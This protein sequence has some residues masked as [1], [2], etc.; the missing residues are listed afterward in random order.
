MLPLVQARTRRCPLLLYLEW[1]YDDCGSRSIDELPKI[2]A[3]LDQKVKF[4]GKEL[5]G[6]IFIPAASMHC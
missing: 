4:I 1:A 5:L 6:T 3:W 2:I